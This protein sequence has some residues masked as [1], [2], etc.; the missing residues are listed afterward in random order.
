M[1]PLIKMSQ[2]CVSVGPFLNQVSVRTWEEA[3]SAQLRPVERE[4][5]SPFWLL[6]PSAAHWELLMAAFH[7]HQSRCQKVQLIFPADLESDEVSPS[8]QLTDGSCHCLH[9]FTGT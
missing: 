7:S 4:K 3:E 5:A 9:V 2:E 8:V 1:F 6:P